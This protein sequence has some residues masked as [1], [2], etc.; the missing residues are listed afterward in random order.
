MEM[1]L[2][3]ITELVLTCNY[4]FTDLSYVTRM[5]MPLELGLLLAFGK[6]TFVASGKRYSALRSIS[7][8]NFADIHYHEGRIRRLIVALSRWIEQTCS[9]KRL[10]TETLLQRYRRLR[11]L[12]ETLGDDFDRLRPREIT[13]LLGVAKDEFKM[14]LPGA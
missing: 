5:N 12:R 11:R 1:R 3:R 2:L 9:R 6:E 7:D 8:L 10:T 14:K 4:G 13:R